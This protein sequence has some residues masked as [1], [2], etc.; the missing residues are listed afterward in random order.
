MRGR[1]GSTAVVRRVVTA[2]VLVATLAGCQG[3][4]WGY[5]VYGQ[6][7]DGTTT[8]RNTPTA[9][10]GPAWVTVDAG[11]FHSCGIDIDGQA[12]CWGLNDGYLLGDGTTTDRPAPVLVQGGAT[13]YVSIDA[14]LLQTCA[15]RS[16]A[17]LWCWGWFG[18]GNY[19]RQP[20]QIGEPGW[21]SVWAGT[22]HSC[23]TRTDGTLW[24]WGEDYYGQ[25]GDGSDA[26]WVEE[27]T[28]VSG[29]GWA[30]VTGGTNHTCALRVDG[31]AWCWGLSDD[32][33]FDSGE[34]GSSSTPVQVPGSWTAIES[35]LRHVCGLR[36]DHTAWC[37]GNNEDGQLGLGFVSRESVKVPTQV[38]G[39]DWRSIS[40]GH[41]FT[42]GLRLDHTAWCWGN[43]NL[44]VLGDGTSIS[45]ASPTPVAGGETWREISSG[46]YHAV[47][48]Q[49]AATG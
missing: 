14:G 43:N 21:S 24:C 22:Y 33:I 13:D 2:V 40:P 42:C 23:G 3:A 41:G 47:G 30:T 11:P 1:A 35:G 6:V 48:V 16:D 4:G 8:D 31:T 29:T 7:G 20:T 39:D 26:N 32:G 36:G 28:Q 45:T 15:I 9:Q 49:R 18:V 34:F 37:W 25:V 38:P 27:P 17:T 5:N 19:H 10:A 12:W 46:R 44:G